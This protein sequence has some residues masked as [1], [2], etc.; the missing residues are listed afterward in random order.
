MASTASNIICSTHHDVTPTKLNNLD[1]DTSETHLSPEAERIQREEGNHKVRSLNGKKRVLRGGD[2]I[3]SGHSLMTLSVAWKGI[4]NKQYGLTAAHA[5]E[6]CGG[7]VSCSVFAFN[8]DEKVEK[9]NGE[10]SHKFIKIG[11]VLVFDKIND[12][13]IFEIFECFDIDPLVVAVSGEHT[14]EVTLPTPSPE[15]TPILPVGEK[16]FMFGAARRGMLGIHT[17]EVFH[18]TSTEF[19]A[20]SF[21]AGEEKNPSGSKKLTY[22]GDCG[23]LY[24]DKDGY[25]WCMHTH[26]HSYTTSQGTKVW[27]SRGPTLQS[28]VNAHP[29]FFVDDP[30]DLKPAATLSTLGS[31]SSEE[32][33]VSHPTSYSIELSEYEYTED[34]G[35]DLMSNIYFSHSSE[36]MPE[37]IDKSTI[38]YQPGVPLS[39]FGISSLSLEDDEAD[40]EKRTARK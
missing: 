3:S 14:C 8:S 31:D 22:A 26:L 25:A 36:E 35:R 21:E 32:A 17:K 28:I 16:V 30:Y 4:R 29:L 11:E 5:F 34:N 38:Q 37:E 19:A 27:I 2:W 40:D 15:N 12:C 7:S 18:S 10:I 24:L 20:K 1:M 6:F 13:A 33:Q 39:C 23:G 9:S